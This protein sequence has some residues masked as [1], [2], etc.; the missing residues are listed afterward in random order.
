M[1]KFSIKLT[2]L[3]CY[4]IFLSFISISLAWF[5]NQKEIAPDLSF[6]AG[7]PDDYVLY[8]IRYNENTSAYSSETIDTIGSNAGDFSISNLQFGKIMNLS[9][10]EPSNYVYYA[11][12]IPKEDGGTV[13][14]GISWGDTDS[15]G[16]H[17]KIRVPKKDENGEIITENGIIQTQLFSNEEALGNIREIEENNS[18]T[19]ISYTAVL[20]EA[21]PDELTSQDALD[22]LFKDAL[23][24]SLDS[25][26]D[27]GTPEAGT[28]SL[29]LS[30]LEGDYYYAYVKLEPNLSIYKYF[31]DYLWDNMPFFLIYEVRVTLSTI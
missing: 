8:Q 14:L 15:N 9:A 18:S 29:D 4:V 7:A 22:E 11:I 19:F 31:I 28:L 26:N 21:A 10:L 17:F 20:S 23:T 30:S 5:S 25:F 16:E 24:K 12:R 1:K 3:L 6:S 2:A 13:S 27:D